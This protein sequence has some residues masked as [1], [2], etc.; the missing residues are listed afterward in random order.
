MSETRREAVKLGLDFRPI[1]VDVGDGVEWDFTA[2]PAPDQWSALVNALKAFTTF[3]DGD[4]GGEEFES[5]L[6]GFRVAMSELI[7]DESQRPVWIEKKYG[8]MVMQAISEALMENWTGFPT[9][10]PSPSGKGSKRTG[11]A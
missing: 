1:P 9:R 2:D 5:A 4:F 10:Q 8:L 3:G 11:S 6:L 7:T